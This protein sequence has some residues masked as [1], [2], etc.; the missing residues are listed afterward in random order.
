MKWPTC[1]QL[2]AEG[3]GGAWTP[4]RASCPARPHLALRVISLR[5]RIWSLAAHSGRWQGVQSEDLWVHGLE[6]DKLA[7]LG[8]VALQCL[9]RHAQ[10]AKSWIRPF[11]DK[12]EPAFPTVVTDRLLF[13]EFGG[14]RVQFAEDIHGRW[15]SHQIHYQ[16]TGQALLPVV[17]KL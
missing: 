8:R 16:S 10:D 4:T 12:D 13:F 1:R 6:D 3:A 9:P 14:Y 11:V 7:A 5:F 17:Y 2:L 15:S